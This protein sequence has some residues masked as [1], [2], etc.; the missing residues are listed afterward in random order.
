[1]PISGK[2]SDIFHYQ[3]LAAHKK[4]AAGRPGKGSGTRRRRG[5]AG[6]R[7]QPECQAET[8]ARS[9]RGINAHLCAH[10]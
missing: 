4:A 1:V 7:R 10:L 8:T 5:F 3:Y 6:C 2:T 9:A